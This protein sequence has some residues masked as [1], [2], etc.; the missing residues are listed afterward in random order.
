[1]AVGFSFW[2]GFK[3]IEIWQKQLFEEG[4]SLKTLFSMVFFSMILFVLSL[5]SLTA[6]G[7][8]PFIYFRF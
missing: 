8:N 6:S 3:K 2:G 1:V 4:K 7:F 5:S